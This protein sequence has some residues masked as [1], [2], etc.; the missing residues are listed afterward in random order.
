MM[1]GHRGKGGRH[2]PANAVDKQ[3]S[4]SHETSS[5]G[6]P[7]SMMSNSVHLVLYTHTYATIELPA[8]LKCHASLQLR[9]SYADGS[10]PS[11]SSAAGPQTASSP[12][13]PDPTQPCS[14]AHTW[15]RT[16]LDPTPAV[17]AA[18]DSAPC[19]RSTSHP[20][21]GSSGPSSCSAHLASSPSALDYSRQIF[22]VDRRELV[23][24]R[25]RAHWVGLAVNPSDRQG[26]GEAGLER[27]PWC[28]G[29]RPVGLVG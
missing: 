14:L 9:S 5:N 26:I 7:K 18:T 19:R 21:S 6:F 10:A 13:R 11:S 25:A 24:L 16:A 27:A 1:P 29:A 15:A 28:P 2:S 12:P 23:R 17:V 8:K 22:V 20:H 4:H 3:P